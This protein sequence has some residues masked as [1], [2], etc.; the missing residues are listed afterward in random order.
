M[1]AP[2]ALSAPEA[3]PFARSLA[4]AS[5]LMLG[6]IAAGLALRFLPKP[7]AWG[8]AASPAGAA[9]FI[10]GA[11][12]AC[13]IGVP[14]QAAAF[15]AGYVFGPWIGGALGLV[16]QVIGCAIDFAWARLAARAWVAARLPSRLCRLDARLAAHPFAATLSLRLLPL[17]NNVALNLLAGVSAVGAAPFLAASAL[18]YLP[19]TVIFVLLGTGIAVARWVEVALAVGLFAASALLG[20]RLL[21]SPVALNATA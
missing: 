1:T 18:G 15:A 19:Q 14:R 10:G 20:W 6:L 13:A 16:A 2:A 12:L 21:R 5:V 3:N 11:A 9:A 7:D 8:L 17:G 4:R